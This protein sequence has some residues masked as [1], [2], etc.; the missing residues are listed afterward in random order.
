MIIHHLSTY[1]S[2][3]PILLGVLFFRKNYIFKTFFYGLLFFGLMQLALSAMA[4]NSINNLWLF[5]INAI[6]FRVFYIWLLA[7]ILERFSKKNI[8]VFSTIV[9]FSL[10]VVNTYQGW[11]NLNKANY[12]IPNTIIVILAISGLYK[13]LNA[14]SKILIKPA[15]WISIG[16]LLYF[17]SNILIFL[18]LD[19]GLSNNSQALSDIYLK[20]H[21]LINIACNILYTISFFTQWKT[22]TLPS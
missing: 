6:L 17:S 4:R 14:N 21:P 2:A 18:A 20:I 13:L 10:V 16:A 11:L 8:F 5:N 7:Y 22:K 12:I 19:F 1:S 15:F 9:F 3:L